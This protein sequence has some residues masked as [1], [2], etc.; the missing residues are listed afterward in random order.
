[1][2]GLTQSSWDISERKQEPKGWGGTLQKT[3]FALTVP[4]RACLPVHVPHKVKSTTPV[5]INR[6]WQATKQKNPNLKLNE[7][8]REICGACGWIGSIDILKTRWNKSRGI[9][10]GGCYQGSLKPSL[11]SNQPNKKPPKNQ[12]TKLLDNA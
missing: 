5:T 3:V 4:L 11:L 2:S 8:G 12:K 10:T 6:S 7:G 1:M 9:C